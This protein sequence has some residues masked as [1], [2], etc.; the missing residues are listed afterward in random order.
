MKKFLLV[1]C[2]LAAA[3][4]AVTMPLACG[5][6]TKFCPNTRTGD[7][8]VPTQDSGGPGG[9]GGNDRDGSTVILD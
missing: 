8:P 1:A 3:A 5:P 9:S 7:C 4:W 2:A 6:Q